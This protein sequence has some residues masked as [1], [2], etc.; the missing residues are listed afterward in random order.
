MH[1]NMLK[2]IRA[3]VTKW[4]SLTM[5]NAFKRT[6]IWCREREN[7]QRTAHSST[8]LLFATIK[9]TQSDVSFVVCFAWTNAIGRVCS[10]CFFFLAEMV[11]HNDKSSEKRIP[12]HTDRASAIYVINSMLQIKIYVIHFGGFFGRTEFALWLQKPNLMLMQSKYLRTKSTR[13]MPERGRERECVCTISICEMYFK[14]NIRILK[15]T[16]YLN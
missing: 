11:W 16:Q 3:I 6:L 7:C 4:K 13:R 8:D 9:C 15:R 14:F 1:T 12:L 10:C 2:I 5:A